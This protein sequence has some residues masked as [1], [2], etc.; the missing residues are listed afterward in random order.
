MIPSHILLEDLNFPRFGIISTNPSAQH[1]TLLQ[2]QK[3]FS[4]FM[5]NG[6]DLHLKLWLGMDF[7]AKISINTF[8]YMPYFFK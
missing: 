3:I 6:I 2:F 5:L 4:I 7:S 1:C 8:N